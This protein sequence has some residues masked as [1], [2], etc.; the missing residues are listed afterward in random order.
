MRFMV[1][2]KGSKESESGA[3]PDKESLMEMGRFNDQLVEAGLM[4]AGEGLHP[5]SEGTRITFADGKPTVGQ[6][7]FANPEQQVAGFWQLTAKSKDEVIQWMK[8]APFKEGEL[9][10]RQIMEDEEFSFA[11]EVVEQE[12]RLRAKIAQRQPS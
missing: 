6:G 1:F 7:P 2:V 3:M 11:P 5:S 8:R 9:E 4:R 12:K 10:I